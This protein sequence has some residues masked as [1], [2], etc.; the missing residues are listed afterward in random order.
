MGY[1]VIYHYHERQSDGK[2]NMEEQKELKKKVGSPLDEIPLNQ[3]AVTV[4]SQLARRDIW[5]VDVEIFEFTKKKI[6]FKEASDG[7]GIVIKNKKFGVKG[8][9]SDLIVVEDS[10]EPSELTVPN[11]NIA[12]KQHI[13]TQVGTENRPITWMMYQVELHQ[14]NDVKGWKF[15]VGKKYP[16]FKIDQVSLGQRKLTTRDD[17]GVI[18]TVPDDYFVPAN[19]LVGETED[20]TPQLQGMP[21]PKL[22]YQSTKPHIDMPV[23]RR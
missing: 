19:R 12:A 8:N 18:R 7:S 14:S 15:T 1:E 17:A 13:V 2:Y 3:L 21:E 6:S 4:M 23:L 16:I 9:E 11:T 22:S 20:L 5:I 10:E